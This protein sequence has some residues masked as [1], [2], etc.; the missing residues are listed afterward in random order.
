MGDDELPDISA[1]LHDLETRARD[2]HIS[3]RAEELG[4]VHRVGDGVAFVEGL[5]DVA[6]DELVVFSNE[7]Y[8]QV[9]DIDRRVVGCVL[10]GTE[11][12]IKAG[13]P[14]KRTGRVS[15]VPVGEALL[16]RAV[17]PLGRP[18]DGFGL[19]EATKHRPIEGDAPGPLQRQPVREP[20]FTGIKVVD[21]A[22]PIGR[23]QRELILGD[24]ETGKTS[25]ALDTIINQR[26]GDVLCV[27]VS[28]GAKRSSV[29]EVLQELRRHDAM[30]HT[31]VVVA[32]ATRPAALQYLAPYAGVAIA[33][34]F[35]YQGRHALI[36][37]DDLSRHA[38][39]YRAL[40]LI[41]RRPP[42]REAYPGDIF[43][44]H[45]RLL[46]RAFKLSEGLS[47]GSVTA[48]PIIETQGG[49]ISDFIPTNLIS[50]TDGQLFL[51][52]ARFAKGQL[53]AV[54]MGKSVSRVGGDAQ[55]ALM[56]EMARH[57]RLDVAQYEDVKGFTRFG[58]LLDEATKHQLA[59]GE[60]LMA[61]MSQGERH[62]LS[63]GAEAAMFWAL[64]QGVL[65]D[66]PVERIPE[67]EERVRHLAAD[68]SELDTALR[69]GNGELA[70]Q[71]KV[72]E[73]WVKQARAR[74]VVSKGEQR[75]A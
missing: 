71:E 44:V 4:R 45:A 33:E 62:T 52:A 32:D 19:V 46:E 7:I 11:Q 38:V 25:I 41:L 34:H 36:L 2:L 5:P 24:R 58:A 26:G 23:G 47:G 50:I 17:D 28:I 48:L 35:A 6:L 15:E 72:L 53:P 37:F 75:E 59:H 57:L 3:P 42:G 12:S 9:L 14:V 16:G 60:R 20:L 1:S 27:Y 56:R 64:Q 21:A 65:D 70:E 73:R 51:D 31:I 74:M 39:A 67:F 43:S 40:S 63:P 55:P 61:V 18:E 68:F 30:G 49:N 10:F 54:D 69:S 8:G 29:A 13:S 66:L 22:I